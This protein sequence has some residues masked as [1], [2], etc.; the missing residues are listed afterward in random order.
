M[1]P[2]PQ[3]QNIYIHKYIAA[4]DSPPPPIRDYLIYGQLLICVSN[5]SVKSESSFYSDQ[6]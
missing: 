3:K 2:P 1:P 4:T 6:I 5:G